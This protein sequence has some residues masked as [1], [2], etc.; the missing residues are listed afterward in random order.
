M[1]CSL[2][3]SSVHR[4]LQAR[5]LEWVAIPF[6]PR[7]QTQVSCIA[8][9]FLIWATGKPFFPYIPHIACSPVP[10]VCICVCLIA[11]FQWWVSVLSFLLRRQIPRC[12]CVCVCVC[13]FNCK[14]PMLDISPVVFAVVTNNSKISR[15]F[16][17][18]V[19]FLLSLDEDWGQLHRSSHSEVHVTAAAP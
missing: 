2:L 10:G 18:N 13:V 6:W 19:Y 14:I 5:I 9:S 8:D 15:S 12:V 7:D 1:D 17:M 4:I 16:K 3:G 11:K